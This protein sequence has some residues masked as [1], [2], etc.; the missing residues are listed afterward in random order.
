MRYNG[1]EMERLMEEVK[2]RFEV[3][4]ETVRVGDIALELLQIKNLDEYIDRLAEE[5]KEGEKLELP[6]WAKLW[7]TSLLLS[8]Y[9]LKLPLREEPVLEIGAGFGLCGLVAAMKG[10]RVI[11]SDID[12][13]ALLFARINIIKNGLT[14]RATVRY[15]DF[16][17]DT[18]EE[19]P[20]YII[21]SEVLYRQEHYR[22]LVKF[23]KRHLTPYSRAI[24]AK[25]YHLKAKKF[26][27]LARE[28]FV[29]REKTLGF[30][31]STEGEN[32]ERHLCNII[33]LQKKGP[34]ND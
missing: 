18:L 28:W 32:P 10:H 23:F 22:P 8:Y 33:E 19:K 31:E 5:T 25:D 27:T 2:K 3:E 24:L 29:I 16:T 15:L 14:H 26:F 13:N 4:F 30:K 20:S 1:W 17:K 6:F 11:I 12:D 9:I 21:G 7:P 34:R